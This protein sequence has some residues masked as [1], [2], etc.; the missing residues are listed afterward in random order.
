MGSDRRY[1]DYE[2]ERSSSVRSSSGRSSSGR[3]SSGRSSSGRSTSGG[4]TSGR[5]SSG[6]STSGRSSSGK[7]SYGQSASGRSS[8]RS[9]SSGRS[10]S[11]GRSSSGERGRER[12]GYEYDYEDERRSR[13]GSR[14]YSSRSGGKKKKKKMKSSFYFL[15]FLGAYLLL[16]LILSAIFL[17]YADRSLKKFEKSQSSYAIE[18]YLKRFQDSLAA[19]QLPEGF[20][21]ENASA[22][23]SSDVVLQT[24]QSQTNGKTLSSEK[25]PNSYNTE[26]PV[27]DILAD[28][29]PVAR[30]TLS[31][32]NERVVFAILT[33]MDW[34]VEK[35]ELVNAGDLTDYTIWAPEGYRITVNG[36]SVG[37]E[38]QTGERESIE[39]F[40]NAK[41]YITAPD[42]IQYRIPAL[43]SEPEVQVTDENGQNVNCNKNDTEYRA[44]YGVEEPMPE[45][46]QKTALDIAETWS[47]FNTADLSGGKYGLD[48]V[49]K[50]LIPDSFYDGLAKGWAGGIDIT[51]TSAHT[52]KNP[53]FENVVVDHYIRYSDDCFS[54]HI[55]FDKPMHLTRTGEDIVD[56]THSTYL[57]ANY[58]GTWCMVDMIADTEN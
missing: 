13:S 26:E 5:S 17:G 29:T 42:I 1:S 50:F 41:E 14:N 20:A 19:G 40:K 54:C 56:S 18:D 7:S 53:P 30:V 36:I 23:E 25:D 16:L 27:Y 2:P 34:N 31:A 12:Y 21:G 38:Y 52:L 28:G 32:Y 43:S 45:D 51:F 35:A 48:T 6:K 37:D 57:F 8:S 44:V 33:I 39:L 49:R 55:S 24:L 9:G 3:S 4:S 22:F 15:C 10:S 47:L 46:L 58:N 11:Q